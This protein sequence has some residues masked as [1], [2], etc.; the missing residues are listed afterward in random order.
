MRDNTTRNTVNTIKMTGCIIL[1]INL[2]ILGG[3]GYFVFKAL[4]DP[5]KTAE[6]IGSFTKNIEDSFN[7][8]YE[9][10]PQDTTSLNTIRP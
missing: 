10:L 2:S 7:K 9:P 4:S 1:I 6:S 5:S 8:G 3:I